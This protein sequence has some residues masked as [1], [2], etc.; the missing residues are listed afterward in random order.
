MGQAGTRQATRLF[1][2]KPAIIANFG[3]LGKYRPKTATNAQPDSI[4]EHHEP[5]GL[6]VVYD[7]HPRTLWPVDKLLIIQ[8]RLHQNS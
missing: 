1:G 5:A 4:G 7:V 2:A 3:A 8:D 6:F